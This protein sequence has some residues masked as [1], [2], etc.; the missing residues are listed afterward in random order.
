L[1]TLG[2]ASLRASYVTSLGFV[3]LRASL[4]IAAVAAAAACVAGC[5][6][7]AVDGPLFSAPSVLTWDEEVDLA[8]LAQLHLG[9][10]QTWSVPRVVDGRSVFTISEAEI[11]PQG[12]KIRARYEVFDGPEGYGYLASDGDAWDPPEV[13]LPAG[14]AVGTTW[15]AD[16]VRAGHTITR[17]CEVM[18][19]DK[20]SG[21][22]VSVCD[23]T[24]DT[25]GRTI[26][27]EHFC[28]GVGWAGYEAMHISPDGEVERRWTTNVKRD[29]KKL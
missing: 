15:K 10:T 4:A 21:G 28:P 11:G 9:I 19:S 12:R 20:C 25:S 16:H 29:G 14:A 26:L 7:H 23:G 5:G 3:S 22:L 18:A 6:H 27:R 13:V 2:F 8:G 1:T 24:S 17:S